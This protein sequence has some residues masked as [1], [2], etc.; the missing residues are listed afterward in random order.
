M[1]PA[2]RNY[3]CGIPCVW[4]EMYMRMEDRL[5]DLPVLERTHA[6][7]VFL[8]ERYCGFVMPNEFFEQCFRILAHAGKMLLRDDEDMPFN[9]RMIIA[10]NA[11]MFRFLKKI[12]K[13]I[14]CRIAMRAMLSNVLF[15]KNVR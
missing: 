2:L 5:A 3:R 10:D 6:P 15:G 9:D 11:K 8:D 4:Q 12:G 13:R 1:V 7:V 14:G